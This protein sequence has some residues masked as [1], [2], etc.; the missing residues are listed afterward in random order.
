[1]PT[2]EMALRFAGE[3]Q[4]LIAHNVANIATPDFRQVD[5][6]AR[7]FQEM[8]AEAVGARRERT[9]G[10]FG[11]LRWEETAE[12]RRG[13]GGRLELRPGTDS[14]GILAHDRNNRDLER[15]MQD[16]VENAAYYRVAVDFLR[17]Q[18]EQLRLAISQRV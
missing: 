6:S 2:L 3:R 18:G 14:P 11:E 7:G 15:L 17:Q 10:A 12:V 4:K 1:M 5:V 16:Q 8:L 9:G 13:V